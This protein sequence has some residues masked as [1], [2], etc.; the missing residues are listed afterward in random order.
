M[1]RNYLKI[2]LRNIIKRKI[3]SAINI[4]GLAVGLAVVILISLFLNDELS[5]DRFHE[6]SE[7]IYRI[8]WMSGNPQT[9]TPHPMAQALVR[10]FPEVEAAVSLSPLWGPG[11]TVRTFSIKSPEKSSWNDEKNILSVDSTFFDVFSFNLISGNKSKILR[12]V[13]GLVISQSMAK[14]YFGIDDPIGKQLAIDSDEQLLMVEGVFEDVPDNSHFHFDFLVSY[15]TMKA[16]APE[17]SEFYEWV[18]F[19]HFNYIKLTKGANS[20]LLEDKLLAWAGGYLDWDEQTFQE[21]ASS[22]SHFGLQPITDIHLKSGIRWELEPN[23]NIS[24]VYIMSA[25]AIFILLIACFNFMNLSTAKSMERANEVGVRKSFGAE[26]SQLYYQFLGESILLSLFSAIL[27]SFIVEIILPFFNYFTGKSLHFPLSDP[28]TI[29]FLFGGSFIVGV[30]AGLFPAAYLSGMKPALIMKGKYSSSGKGQ[31]LRKVLVILQFTISMFLIAGSITIISQLNFLKNMDLGFNKEEVIVIP[32]HSQELR[33]RFV[34]I[35]SELNKI[36]GVENVSAASNIPGKQFNQNPI[37]LKENPENRV[38]V[39]QSFVEYEMLNTLGLTIKNGRN[40]DKNRPVDVRNSFIVNEATIVALSLENPIGSEI[41]L[42]AD[43]DLIEGEIIGVVKDYNYLSLHEPIRPLIMQLIPAYNHI[44]VKLNTKNFEKTV[45]GINATMASLDNKHAFE[46][47]FLDDTL[48]DQYQN[49]S[50]I[51][52]VFGGFAILAII[53]A[54]LGLGGLAAINF[55]FRK[56]EIGI[57]KVLGASAYTLVLNLLRE[58]T[59]MVL[60]SIAISAPFYWVVVS[61]WLQNFT[62][63]IPINPIVFLLSG[64]VLLVISWITLSY[65]TFNTIRANPINALKEE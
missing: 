18:D 13:G 61:N 31:T 36:E 40:F 5:Y 3:Y 55:S 54:C 11:L 23:G 45:E 38:D 39:A 9:R 12:N 59:F 50:R 34:T 26:R 29:I 14:K 43:G 19:G 2:A 30:L 25:A 7:D 58:Y 33:E 35:Q 15:V 48:S 4:A 57:K 52:V 32:L 65:L 6:D 44:L 63:R 22:N 21:L 64:L 16:F 1:I 17:E 51:S 62:Y 10:D 8:A 20:Q 27:A 47:E 24:Y 42:D 53:I 37:Y 49:E 46:F 56:K 41:V 28:V 60:I